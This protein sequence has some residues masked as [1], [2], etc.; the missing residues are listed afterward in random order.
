MQ[1]L[2]YHSIDITDRP[3][4]VYIQLFFHHSEGSTG[5]A[6]WFSFDAKFTVRYHLSLNVP[7]PTAT[8]T[9]DQ[10]PDFDSYSDSSCQKSHQKCL[11]LVP[12]L[13]PNLQ[14]K[15]STQGM[16]RTLELELHIFDD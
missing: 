8:L 12:T 15:E 9:P 5:K 7:A 3:N 16:A 14:K 1:F 11:T 13:I 2:Y 6:K 10:F 4:K